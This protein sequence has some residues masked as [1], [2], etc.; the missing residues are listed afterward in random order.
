MG[1]SSGIPLTD[2]NIRNDIEAAH[3]VFASGI[4]LTC[5]GLNVALHCQLHKQDIARLK[6]S[7][8]PRAQ[9]ISE[10][11]GL[12]QQH[13]PNWQAGLPFLHGPLAVAALCHPSVLT[14]QEMPIRLLTKGPFKGTT[15]A[16]VPGGTW[17]EAATRVSAEDA[18]EWMLQRWL[19]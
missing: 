4:P 18:R 11:M 6:K 12:W 1:G 7:P 10:L 19:S 9:V 5:V 14:F 2:W 8:T 15:V 3:K 13:R 16:R 17:V